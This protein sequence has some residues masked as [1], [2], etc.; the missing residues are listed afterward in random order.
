MPERIKLSEEQI[1]AAH[2][3][4]CPQCLAQGGTWVNLRICLECG[5]VGCCDASPNTHATKHWQASGHALLRT[6]EPGEDW[7][8]NYQTNAAE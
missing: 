4:G 7:V 3:A 8:W 5:Q 6:L 2:A 1:R